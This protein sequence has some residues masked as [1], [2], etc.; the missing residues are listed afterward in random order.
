MLSALKTLVQKSTVGP[1]VRNGPGTDVARIGSPI[2]HI[3]SGGVQT[4]VKKRCTNCGVTHASF[5]GWRE[6]NAR[7]NPVSQDDDGPFL[8]PL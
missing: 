4:N 7:V 8:N 5:R 2:D 6:C 1:T 3:I